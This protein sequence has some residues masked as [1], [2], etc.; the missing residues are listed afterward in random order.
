MPCAILYLMYGSG[1]I[2]LLCYA[3][4]VGLAL[5]DVVTG[6]VAP[7]PHLAAPYGLRR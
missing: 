6:L 2:V 4:N 1:G 5:L 7:T 3:S